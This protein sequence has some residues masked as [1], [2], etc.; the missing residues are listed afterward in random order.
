MKRGF[1]PSSVCGTL[2]IMTKLAETALHDLQR[3]WYF[4]QNLEMLLAVGGD[5]AR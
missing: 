3:F 5:P 1:E 2:G 4:R